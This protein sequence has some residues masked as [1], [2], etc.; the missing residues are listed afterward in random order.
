MKN[1]IPPPRAPKQTEYNTI[2]L[3][4]SS[5]LIIIIIIITIYRNLPDGPLI[6]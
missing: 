6:G 2:L 4:F 3:F 5:Y 1:R